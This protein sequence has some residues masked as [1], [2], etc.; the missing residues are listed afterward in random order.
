MAGRS[1]N[2]AV[3]W[4]GPA[5]TPMPMPRR[6]RDHRIR[7]TCRA[8]LARDQRLMVASMEP[9]GA[10]ASYDAAAESY[11]AALLLAERRS[12][13]RGFLGIIDVPKDRLHVITEDVGGAFG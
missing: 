2:V 12:A 9:R 11:T 13:A 10:T 1:S 5:V 7:E 4:P 3:D 8:G 6:W